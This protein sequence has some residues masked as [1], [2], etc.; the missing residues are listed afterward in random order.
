MTRLSRRCL[1]AALFLACGGIAAAQNP[2][3]FAT[4]EPTPTP[5]NVGGLA[6]PVEP[7]PPMPMGAAPMGGSYVLPSGSAP[8]AAPSA[9]S[10]FPSMAIPQAACC[11]AAATAVSTGCCSAPA[12]AP[13]SRPAA[14]CCAA[15]VGG[16]PTFAA[17]AP[18]AMYAGGPNYSGGCS[19]C[20]GSPSMQ[21]LQSGYPQ[22]Y[23][24]FYGAS[25]G[26][27]FNSN[28]YAGGYAT[29]AHGSAVS[30]AWPT[31]YG[32]HAIGPAYAGYPMGVSI[33]GT[34][35][36]HIRNPY[37]SDRRPWYTPGAGA[38]TVSIV[39]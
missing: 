5:A 9:D 23:S 26:S 8:M 11:G 28:L 14:T 15:A 22:P 38:R 27:D 21:V 29:G 35:G 39:W 34:A 2:L 1:A 18:T 24:S 30:G 12:A 4:P 32:Q 7:A 33:G 13:C 16:A 36:E 10:V 25:A 31:Y 17:F 37:Y 6:A 3:V 19:S 20:G